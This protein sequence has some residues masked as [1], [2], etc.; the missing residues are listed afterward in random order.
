M[1]EAARSDTVEATLQEA[2]HILRCEACASWP[3]CAEHGKSPREPSLRE[4][5]EMLRELVTLR[6]KAQEFERY[7]RETREHLDRMGTRAA[8]A[9]STRRQLESAETDNLRLSERNRQLEDA[10]LALRKEAASGSREEAGRIGDWQDKLARAAAG[11][12]SIIGSVLGARGVDHV[13]VAADIQTELEKERTYLAD[14]FDGLARDRRGRWG[15]GGSHGSNQYLHEA[16]GLADA[17]RL[18]LS[19]R[20]RR[21]G[22]GMSEGERKAKNA[23]LARQ[24]SSVF[25]GDSPEEEEHG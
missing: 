15:A 20:G 4:A 8:L 25:P 6:N 23:L 1:V 3:G 10:N 12:D 21:A 16:D 11:L 17:S 7:K 13:Q 24:P 19:R 2:N 14:A 22:E 18:V 9:D 5:D